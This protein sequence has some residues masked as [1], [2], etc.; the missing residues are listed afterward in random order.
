MR[1][2]VI[3]KKHEEEVEKYLVQ[4]LNDLDGGCYSSLKTPYEII[5]RLDMSDCCPEQLTIYRISKFNTVEKLKINNCW[6]KMNDPLYISVTDDKGNI[7]F[8]GYGTDH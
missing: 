3:L 4:I 6:H 8:D 1:N 7:V 2:K 5:E